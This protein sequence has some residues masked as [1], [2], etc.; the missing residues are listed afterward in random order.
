MADAAAAM[1]PAPVTPP[2][3]EA[4]AAPAPAPVP[5]P[6]A[7]PAAP[8]AEPRVLHVHDL[9]VR[10]LTARVV[11]AHELHAATGSVGV[12][13]PSDDDSLLQLEL[14]P[15][16]LKVDEL[17]VDVLFAHDIKAG[18]IHVDEAHAHVKIDKGDD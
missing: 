9:D 15:Q 11:H 8:P 4:D 10:R 18:W 13:L 12:V 14:G 2:P 5:S 16:N 1:P 6:D 17:T 3:V 7:A